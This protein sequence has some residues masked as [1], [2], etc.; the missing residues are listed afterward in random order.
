MFQ[1]S[2]FLEKN[3]SKDDFILNLFGNETEIKKNLKEKKIESNQIKITNTN[4][5][6]SDDDTPLTAIKNSKDTEIAKRNLLSKKW[7][8]RKSIKL[9]GKIERKKNIS[10]YSLSLEQ[11]NAILE[12]RLQKLTAY[13]IA[14]IESEI[15]KLA[16]LILEYNKIINSKKEL[17]KLITEE[18][19]L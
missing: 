12:L 13:G 19:D 9:I 15:N 10:S 3:N 8:I 4:S 17:N 14:E 1:S 16:E 7:K 2:C 5:V 6:V 11:V 18:L